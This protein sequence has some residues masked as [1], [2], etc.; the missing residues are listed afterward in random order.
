MNWQGNEKNNT[1]NDMAEINEIIAKEAIEGIRQADKAINS[2]DDAILDIIQRLKVLDQELSGNSKSYKLLAQGQKLAIIEA[3]NL[4]RQQKAAEAANKKVAATIEKVAAI[5]KKAAD[6]DKERAIALVMQVKSID[7]A[8][9][10][11]KALRETIRNLD[12]TTKEGAKAIR[13]YNQQVERNTQFIRQNSDAATK[14]KMNIGNYKDAL[15]NLGPLIAGAFSVTAIVGFGKAIFKAAEDQERANKKLLF[16]L[17]GNKAAFSDMARSASQLQSKFGIPDE[18]IMNLQVMALESGKTE[19]ETKKLVQAAIE[20]STVTGKDLNT[21]FTMLNA[22]YAGAA[23]G[24]N[25]ID[26]EFGNLTK[27]QL[28]NGEAIDLVLNKYGGIAEQA[29]RPT[30]LLNHHGGSSW[31]PW[32]LVQVAR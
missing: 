18:E 22:T 3:Q 28:K 7:D 12:A 17:Q 20:L 6:R 15:K 25:R 30:D 9:K 10:Q 21:S 13:E 1:K 31:K 27:D 11:N 8:N 29:V 16:S 14:Q 19:K 2:F 23:K 32:A 4:Q 5:Q 24:L 26:A